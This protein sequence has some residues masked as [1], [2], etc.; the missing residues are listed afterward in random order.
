ME[1]KYSDYQLSQKEFEL[2]LMIHYRPATVM[3]EARISL[4]TIVT[5]YITMMYCEKDEL[6][7]TFEKSVKYHV[8]HLAR[9]G[10][11]GFSEEER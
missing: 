11:W 1:H 9:E 3:L 4:L 10:S 7:F 8:A 6:Q 2:Q 5:A